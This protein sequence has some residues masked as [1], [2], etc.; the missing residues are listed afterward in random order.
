[1]A[2]H[3]LHLLTLGLCFKAGINSKIHTQGVENHDQRFFG[4]KIP[5]NYGSSKMGFVLVVS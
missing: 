4:L 5:L 2:S 3:P 1:M